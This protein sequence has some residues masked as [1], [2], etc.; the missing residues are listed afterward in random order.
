[1]S[2]YFLNKI[3]D[4]LLSNKPV[5]KKPE[6]IVEKKE[7]FKPLSN[8][9]ETVIQQKIWEN[10]ET[11]L[12]ILK[13]ISGVQGESLQK[14]YEIFKK[15]KNNEPFKTNITLSQGS[16]KERAY[17]PHTQLN[18]KNLS[19]LIT[20]LIQTLDKPL[21]ITYGGRK[22][23]LRLSPPVGL[24]VCEWEKITDAQVEQLYN[25]LK[26]DKKINFTRTAVLKPLV[27]FALYELYSNNIILK[28][29]LPSG[30]G[31]ELAQVEEF[32]KSLTG[33][34]P[35]E[36]LL[37]G[38]NQVVPDVFFNQ[39]KKIPGSGKADI[40][41]HNTQTGKDVFWISFKDASFIPDSTEA[42]QFQ[43]WG[44]LKT[45]YKN[46][47][48]IRDIIDQFLTRVIQFDFIKTIEPTLVNLQKDIK[49][50][51]LINTVKKLLKQTK[52]KKVHIMP[53]RAPAVYFNLFNKASSIDLDELRELALKGIY[54][55]DF[56]LTKKQ[57]FGPENVNLILQTPK[58][59]K[60][61][62]QR[63]VEE[64]ITFIQML[65]HNNSHIIKN[66]NLPNTA[67]YLPCITTRFSKN[68]Y[69]LFNNDTEL[70]LDVRLLIYPIGKVNKNGK[71]VII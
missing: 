64:E 30:I 58:P 1:M 36:I 2:D 61:L 65:L 24:R 14:L 4:S 6:P 56:S 53:E 16:P 60:F 69:F 66:P 13:L 31:A 44:S 26:S 7:S 27:I 12:D 54:G 40:A 34:P 38:D 15:I 9:Y 28:E 32:N 51:E 21:I 33:L 18:F 47:N 50:E 57:E 37:P 59:I 39:A 52:L 3:Y 46:N 49:N 23:K 70:L 41:L 17:D 48:G 19:N 68:M 45:M 22:C 5:P 67:S 62:L 63:A 35:V 43:Q 8:V 25:N 20:N 55:E 11:N 71:E 29:R 42:P 10:T